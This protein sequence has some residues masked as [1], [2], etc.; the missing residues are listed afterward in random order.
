MAIAAITRYAVP[1]IK[2]IIKTY[3]ME[4][5]CDFAYKAIRAANQTI[6]PEQWEEKRNKVE[7]Y[8][9]NKI[10]KM[11]IDLDY[12]DLDNIIEGLVNLVKEEK[13]KGN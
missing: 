11:N 8:L 3:Q 13:A 2:E 9:L 1:W 12:E 4:R 7:K 6:T 5:F 10:E